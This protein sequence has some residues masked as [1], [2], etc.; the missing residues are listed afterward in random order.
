MKQ[1]KGKQVFNDNVDSVLADKIIDHTKR[2][3]N[4]CNQETSDST[5]SVNPH[6]KDCCMNM[7]RSK[8]ITLCIAGVLLIAG[9]VVFFIFGSKCRRKKKWR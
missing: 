7:S 6:R 2:N 1:A 3:S 5:S 4:T 9:I 8:C